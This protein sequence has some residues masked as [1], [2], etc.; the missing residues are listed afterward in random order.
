MHAD[1]ASAVIM[2]AVW[3]HL[4]G[5]PVSNARVENYRRIED[6]V[7]EQGI[8]AFYYRLRCKKSGVRDNDQNIYKMLRKYFDIDFKEYKQL[9]RDLDS[10]SPIESAE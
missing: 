5:H 4:H 3:Y 10:Q 9:A 8:E 1:D 2:N 6:V 7:R